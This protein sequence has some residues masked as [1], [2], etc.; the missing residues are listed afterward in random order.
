MNWWQFSL[1]HTLL[2]CPLYKYIWQENLQV[3]IHLYGYALMTECWTFLIGKY[4]GIRIPSKSK[5]S[6][7]TFFVNTTEGTLV[8]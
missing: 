5:Q 6:T 7:L 3:Y 4:P 1:Y 8:L 2:I